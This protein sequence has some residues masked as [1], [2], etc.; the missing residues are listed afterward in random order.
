VKEALALLEGGPE[1]REVIVCSVGYRSA[2]FA[3]ELAGAGF[4][5]VRNLEGS[6]FQWA[7][8]GH[9]VHRDR[10][11]ERIGHEGDEEMPAGILGQLLFPVT[12]R[13][14]HCRYKDI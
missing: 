11:P 10:A 5:G 2:Y 6:I 7:N 3:E 9:A 12:S 8:S 13:R 1:D 14:A 4:T